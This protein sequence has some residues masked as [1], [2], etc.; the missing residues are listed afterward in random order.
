[1]S[2]WYK[3]GYIDPDYITNDSDAVLGKIT[4]GQSIA[5][6]GYVGGS[7]G[8]IIPA[9]EG[10]EKY[11]DFQVVACPYPV[12]TEGDEPWFQEIAAESNDPVIAITTSCGKDNEERYKEAISWCNEFYT[13]EGKVL[14]TFGIE[15]VTFTKEEKKPEEIGKDGEKYKYTYTNLIVDDN[16]PGR[17]E[18]GAHSVEAALWHFMRPANGPGLNQH[19]DYLNGFY[20]Y[21]DQKDAIKI[22]NQ[23]IDTAK[24]HILPPYSFTDDETTRKNEI[25]AKAYDTLNAS[26]S[27]IIIGKADIST[28]DAAIAKAKKDGYDELKEIHQTALD[29]YLKRLSN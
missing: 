29:R 7:L 13:E 10:N 3:K 19:T 17:E 15:G 22:W 14:K 21:Q 27:N 12:L 25:T 5:S 26:I 4:S 9:M 6:Y 18:I 24:K 8:K 11:P 1:M 23:Y 28:Y 2:D 16:D 20:P